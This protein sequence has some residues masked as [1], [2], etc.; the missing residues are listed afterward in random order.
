MSPRSSEPPHAT[1]GDAAA[2]AA[3]LRG[4]SLTFFLASRVLPAGVRADAT[5]LYAFCRLADDAIDLGDDYERALRQLRTRLNG[6]YAAEPLPFPV[7]RALADVVRTHAVPRTLLEALLEGFEWDAGG[8]QYETLEQLTDYAARVA[9]TVGAMM[10]LL[11]GVR[12]VDAVARACDLGVAM[13]LTNIA[14]DVGEDASRGRLYLPR[15]W[16]REEGLDPDAWLQAPVHSAAL[17]RVIE[18]VLVAADRLYR[19]ADA[20]IAALP[21]GCRPAIRAARLL[22][23]EIGHEVRR[24]GCD[25]VASRA[26]V[27]ARRKAVLLSQA[28]SVGRSLKHEASVQTLDAILFLVDAV[29]RMPHPVAA[30][31]PAAWWRYDQ[32]LLRVVAL[33]EDLGH[34][35]RLAYAPA[36]PNR[37]P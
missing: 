17:A 27:P 4:G 14:R 9:G 23:A 20:G 13:Q 10:A 35:D 15:V 29:Q 16:M 18:R 5:A 36:T 3:L 22:Y 12:A 6:I 19:Q 30:R 26:V 33:F 1:A 28:L 21:R 24:R 25:A 37:L 8:R 31:M 34:R 7:D 2:C 32:R 11:M